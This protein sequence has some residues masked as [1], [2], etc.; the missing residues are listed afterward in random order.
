MPFAL[1]R[2]CS[3]AAAPDLGPSGR[4]ASY[5]RMVQDATHTTGAHRESL[6]SNP[7]IVEG[8]VRSSPN[9]TLLKVA[10]SEWRAS[11]R[12]LDIGC[13]AGRNAVPL[14]RALLGKAIGDVVKAGLSEA[15][16]VAIR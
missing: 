7:R 8:F 11:A 6:W 15:E 1:S 10:A 12:L 5:T 13:G 4:H 2:I 3:G 9:D 14:A 16:I